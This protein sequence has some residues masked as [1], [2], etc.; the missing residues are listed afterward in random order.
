[1][2]MLGAAVSRLRRLFGCFSKKL[3]LTARSSWRRLSAAGLLAVLLTLWL[4]P[5]RADS[6]RFVNLV[7][8][9]PTSALAKLGGAA[10][11]VS[12]TFRE[13]EIQ[14]RLTDV[15]VGGA[16]KA[17]ELVTTVDRATLTLKL[18]VIQDIV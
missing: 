9:K 16:D 6:I 13:K 10:G 8:F 1:M 5:V 17:Q 18:S 11:T 2:V 14:M 7:K 15:A 12:T 4:Q 3:Q